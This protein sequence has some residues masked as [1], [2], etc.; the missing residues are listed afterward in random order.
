MVSA[1]TEIFGNVVLPPGELVPDGEVVSLEWK[2][3][4]RR[5]LDARNGLW[6]SLMR[7]DF[8][9][10]LYKKTD[11]EAAE[12]RKEAGLILSAYV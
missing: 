1:L 12:I 6:K 7:L 5:T 11:E 4:E 9:L 3:I 2:E 10:Y 8:Y